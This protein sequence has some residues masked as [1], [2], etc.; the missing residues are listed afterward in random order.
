MRL[1]PYQRRIGSGALLAG[2]A[3]A[4]A[5]LGAAAVGTGA[6]AWRQW[7][8]HAYDFRNRIAFVSG[9][10][11]GLGFALAQELASRGARVAICARDQAE[12]DRALGR[13]A[14]SR[15]PG[16]RTFAIAADLREPDA[17]AA[18][19]AAV[20]RHWGPIEVLVHNAGI[21]QLGP[22][23]Q[24]S[25]AE[26]FAAMDIHCWAALRLARAVLPA[27]L[28]RKQGRIANIASIGGLI[29]VPH[30]L[31]YT[32]SKFA[33]V[34]LSQGL[35]SEVRR[36]GVRVT[37][38]CPFLTR[39]GSQE[40]VELVGQ[41]Q[42]EFAWFAA[43]GSLPVPGLNQSAARAARHI[44]NGIARG[45][46]QLTLALPGKLAAWAHG[47]APSAVVGAMALADRYLLPASPRAASGKRS[48]ADSYTPAT[49]RALKPAIRAAG[50]R[51]NQPGA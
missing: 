32:T 20:E 33:L 34:G 7:R 24:M 50:R 2:G 40:R 30:M 39:T 28:E 19:I 48:G 43:S 44:V 17:P 18:A 41:H 37:C 21:I 6:Y 27:M 1:K 10:S 8:N 16:E 49:A 12:L 22:W 36:H 14:G 42:R 9:G 11:R 47:L 45:Q 23:D 35:A 26:F 3:A 31:P 15:L 46:A 25:E 38:V 29:A 4:V 13:L 5:G 51:W